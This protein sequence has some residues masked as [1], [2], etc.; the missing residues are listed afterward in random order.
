MVGY[1]RIIPKFNLLLSIYAQLN[2]VISRKDKFKLLPIIVVQIFLSI[3][4]VISI[5]IIG[6]VSTLAVS[7]VQSKSSS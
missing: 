5:V 6:L 4:D 1:R 3:L 2:F 7:G